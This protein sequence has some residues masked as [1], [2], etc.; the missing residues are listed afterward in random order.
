M[1]FTLESDV[2]SAGAHAFSTT[3]WSVVLG[4]ADGASSVGQAALEVL[5][6]K[7]WYPLYA[8]IRRRGFSAPEAEDLTQAFFAHILER[9]AL[10]TVS[11][12]KGKFRSFLLVTLTNFLNDEY[13]KAQ[14]KKRGGGVLLESW[15]AV[16]A[17]E[18]YRHEPV[19]NFAPERLFE[20]R[21]AYT[22]VEQALAELRQEYERGGRLAL[23]EAL[24]P[25]LVDSPDRASAE[26][27]AAHLGMNDGAVKVALHRLQRRFGDH[28]R[29]AVARTVASPGQVEEEIR[30]LFSV[31]SD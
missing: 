10:G 31:I 28:L 5:C 23:F 2:A 26:S 22:L 4:A 15:D 7:Y 14:A 30:Y 12:A 18:R 24:R 16:D 27:T 1:A 6:R 29:A 8:F 3:H 21:W 17:E 25:L 19:D 9:G 11:P 13:R 20:R